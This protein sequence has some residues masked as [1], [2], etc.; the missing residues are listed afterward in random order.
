MKELKVQ[1]ANALLVV[2]TVAA[3]IAA[4]IN[5]QQQSK[6]RLPDDGIAWSEL[7]SGKEKKVQAVI[8]SNDGPGHRAGLKVGDVVVSINGA[9]V[10][11]AIAVPQILARLGAW[12]KAEY[13]IERSNVQVKVN[14]YVGEGVPETAVYYQYI[15]GAA[16][17]LIGLFVFVRRGNA[18]KARH[19]YILC[20][21][22]FVLSTFHYT[23]KLN[24]FDKIIYWGNLGAGL[25]GPT[26]F[27]HFC[28]SFP[29]RRPWLHGNRI[30]WLYTPATLIFGLFLAIGTGH[31]PHEIRRLR[32]YA[33]TRNHGWEPPAPGIT[34]PTRARSPTSRW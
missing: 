11:S 32:V 33:A 16:Y 34:P 27:L 21:V 2:L 15:V 12:S 28:L 18:V 19:F 17:L 14:V 10:E 6:Y 5:F 13:L 23:G 25:F 24:N 9:T 20:L 1:L 4:G 26:I 31:C 22:S 30:Y 7:G 3:M 8:V 29:E